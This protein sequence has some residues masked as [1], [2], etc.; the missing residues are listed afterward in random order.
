MTLFNIKAVDYGTP[1]C[2]VDDLLVCGGC[3]AVSKVTLEGTALIT[4][5][6]FE[7]LTD[8]EKKDLTF[9]ARAVTKKHDRN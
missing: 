1:I 8:E 3:G 7:A 5:A 4:T 2:Q 6:E 9:A